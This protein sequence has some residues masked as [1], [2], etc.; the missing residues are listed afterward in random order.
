MQRLQ[1]AAVLL[2]LVEKLKA[3]GSWCGETHIQKATYF[4]QDLTNV[5]LGYRFILYK[6]GPFSFDLGNEITSMLADDLVELKVQ[7][8][9]YGP[10]ILAGEGGERVKKRFPKLIDKYSKQLEAVTKKLGRKGVAELERLATALYVTRDNQVNN[11]AESRAQHIHELKPHVSLALAR[12]AVDELDEFIRSST[13]FAELT[14][15]TA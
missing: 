15:N 1:R 4:L 13:D 3:A 9:P 11:D 5:P 10:S 14:S 8:P 7:P 6:H 2:A 12:Q